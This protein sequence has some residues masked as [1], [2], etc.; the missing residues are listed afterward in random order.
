[1][2]FTPPEHRSEMGNFLKNFQQDWVD[3]VV[4]KGGDPNRR[5]LN[6][7]GV[8]MFDVPVNLNPIVKRILLELSQDPFWLV[9]D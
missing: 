5:T 8:W 1:M 6:P 9:F 7:E 2:V 4:P 3:R